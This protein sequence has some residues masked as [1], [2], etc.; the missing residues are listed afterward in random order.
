MKPRLRS[1]HPQHSLSKAKLEKLRK[2]S[3]EELVDSLRPGQSGSLKVKADGTVMDGHHRVTVLRE[4]GYDV[5]QL[6]REVVGEE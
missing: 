5:D 2:S 4:R 3:T 6:D 1:L